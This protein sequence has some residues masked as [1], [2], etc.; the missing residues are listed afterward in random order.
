ME[1]LVKALDKFQVPVAEKAALL[2]IL[3]PMRGDIVESRRM[4]MLTGQ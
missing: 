2:G 4:M 1:D 3:A